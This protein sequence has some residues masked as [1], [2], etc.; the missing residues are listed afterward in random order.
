MAGAI[1]AKREEARSLRR[2]AHL[3]MLSRHT[4][5]ARIAVALDELIADTETQIVR[6][7]PDHARPPVVEPRP[8]KSQ[9]GRAGRLPRHQLSRH[10]ASTGCCLGQLR[11][12]H[13][14]MESFG[15][16]C[17][18]LVPRAATPRTVPDAPG[19]FSFTSSALGSIEVRTART[20]RAAL[21]LIREKR[22]LQ[23]RGLSPRTIV[24]S[25]SL[26][27]GKRPRRPSRRKLRPIS[28]FAAQRVRSVI[29]GAVRSRIC[30]RH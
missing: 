19:L 27:A 18:G 16:G 26:V 11:Q 2:I 21:S 23:S 30:P 7:K 25:I 4:H 29:V 28:A 15:I 20:P 12:K 24:A 22:V 3:R 1:D 9:G 13:C 6:A 17:E 14:Q 10:Q 8:T 5:D